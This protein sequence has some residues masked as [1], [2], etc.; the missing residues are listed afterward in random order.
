M[1]SIPFNIPFFVGVS[2][3]LII[4]LV[5]ILSEVAFIAQLAQN[6]SRFAES[7]ARFPARGPRVAFVVTVNEVML[8]SVNNV[9]LHNVNHVLLS[10]IL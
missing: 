7:R 3:Y 5:I 6:C 2:T 4:E 9:V 1:S 10:C 8:H